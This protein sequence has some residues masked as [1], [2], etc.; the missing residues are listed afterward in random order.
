MNQKQLYP[1]EDKK[2][3]NELFNDADNNDLI[4][5]LV[6]SKDAIE[7]SETAAR[8]KKEADAAI[9]QARAD[10]AALR[11]KTQVRNCCGCC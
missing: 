9:K 7:K 4:S 10:A 6:K 2:T 1:N 3:G 5:R 11:E 8:L